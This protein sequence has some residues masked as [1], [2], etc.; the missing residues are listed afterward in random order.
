MKTGQKQFC[1]RIVSVGKQNQK[2]IEKSFYQSIADEKQRKRLKR[3]RDKFYKGN[4]VKVQSAEAKIENAYATEYD[5]KV[6]E[7]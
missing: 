3:I 7:M 1:W 4:D 5:G 6:L 2:L